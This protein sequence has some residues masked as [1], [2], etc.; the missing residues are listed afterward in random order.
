MKRIGNS[1]S[2]ATANGPNVRLEDLVNHLAEAESFVLQWRTHKPP[3][4]QPTPLRR[5]IV[6]DEKVR[7]R[8]ALHY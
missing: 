3:V 5:L 7:K 4:P 2:D 8:W 1:A 6:I